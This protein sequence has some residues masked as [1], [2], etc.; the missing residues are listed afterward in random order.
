[1]DLMSQ[2]GHNS[3]SFDTSIGKGIGASSFSG[4][5]VAESAAGDEASAYRTVRFTLPDDIQ[6]RLRPNGQT[7]SIR[8]EP[9]HLGP[10]RL[11]LTIHQ[12]KLR[13]R[14]LVDSSEARIL[15]E[16]SLDRLNR[17]LAKANIEVDYIEVAV[18]SDGPRD[19]LFERQP[20]WNQK[21]A[22]AGIGSNESIPVE[23]VTATWSPP[24][25]SNSYAGQDSVNILA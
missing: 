7:I 18:D 13:A 17:Q 5:I 24:T 1:T 14:V 12:N 20:H 4:Q 2:W 3:D 21:I 8:I 6:N 9:E 11:A 16:H 15:V 10:A 23:N 25:T 19:E 22:K